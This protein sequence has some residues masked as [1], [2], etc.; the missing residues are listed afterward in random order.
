MTAIEVFQAPTG[1][2]IRTVVR[3]GEPW[4]VAAD[5]C[6]A[7]EL[8]NPRSSLALLDDDEKGVHGMDTP[9]GQQGVTVVTE[10]GLYALILRS[11]K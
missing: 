10:S 7:L 9:G 2:Q 1:Q 6:D 5:V 4:F 11:R 8:G 3:D